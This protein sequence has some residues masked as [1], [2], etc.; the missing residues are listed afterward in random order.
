MDKLNAHGLVPVLD[1]Q[2]ERGQAIS[3]ICLGMQLLFET[4]NE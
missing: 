3:R 1:R 4:S 2:V